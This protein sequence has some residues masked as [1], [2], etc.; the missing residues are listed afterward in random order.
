M[1]AIAAIA[2]ARIA[3]QAGHAVGIT[4]RKQVTRYCAIAAVIAGVALAAVYLALGWAGNHYPIDAA[5]MDK[6]NAD[7]THLGVYLLVN[8]A[9]ATYGAVGPWL[10]AIIVLL[11]CLTTAIGLI[12]KVSD[13]FT[14]QFSALS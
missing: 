3:M 5:T 9:S 12:E 1:D 14:P 7:G 2:V 6:I 8:I 11:A 10:V 4:D 13:K